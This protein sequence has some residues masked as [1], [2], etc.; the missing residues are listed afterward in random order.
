MNKLKYIIGI[1]LF[2]SIWGFSECVIGSALND[3]GLPSGMIMTGFFALTFLLL[4][5]IIYK[6]PGMQISIG[7][8]AGAL[9]LFNPFVGC[10]IC[11]SIAIMSEA[12]L[13]ELI[14]YGLSNNLKELKTPLIQ[15]SMGILTGYLIYIGGYIT[16]QI[17][18]PIFSGQ[19]LFIEN[20]IV[21]LPNILSEGIIPSLTAGL[22]FPF[23]LTLKNLDLS[24]KNRLYYPT[25]IG[26][27]SFCWIFVVGLWYISI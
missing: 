19:S 18:T 7:L 24:I 8:I 2:G 20:I 12:V 21:F 1:L 25:T 4:S 9:R 23:L 10:H 26:I 16:T 14:F 11:S 6:K 27:S 5:K 22:I 17:S 13:F 3:F 15:A